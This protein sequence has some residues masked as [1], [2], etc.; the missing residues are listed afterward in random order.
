MSGTRGQPKVMLPVASPV[1]PED[2][3]TVEERLAIRLIRRF[4]EVAHVERLEPPGSVPT[5][6]WRVT[7]ADGRMADVEVI[8]ATNEAGRG[9]ESQFYVEKTDET[10]R[11]RRCRR[12][13]PDARLSWMWDVRVYA[14][15]GSV[16]RKQTA[17]KLVEKLILVLAE[18]EAEGG[19]PEEMASRAH[20]KLYDPASTC[21]VRIRRPPRRSPQAGDGMARTSAV[22]LNPVVGEYGHML[23]TVQKCINAK[24]S[25][26]QM[27]NAPS[28]RWLFVVLDDNMAAVQLDDYFG[29]A[30]LEL[31]ASER[32]PFHVLDKL[33]F[34][35]FD[36]VWVTGRSFQS[37]DHIVLRLFKTGDAPQHQV[38]RRAEVLAGG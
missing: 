1:V 29:P 9:F 33:A 18:V 37:R 10:G 6:D 26:R 11:R 36:E 32:C 34:D 5:P 25:K 7:T 8:W 16:S 4:E 31:D 30:C 19:T 24:T 27:E 23:S 35:Y 15:T 12:E 13:W 3:S 22:T 28:L 38:V 2:D 21:R 20:D 14:Q 17:K